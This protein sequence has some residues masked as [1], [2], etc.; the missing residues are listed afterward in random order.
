LFFK[1]TLPD[2][3]KVI[4]QVDKE[5]E[6]DLQAVIALSFPPT[7]TI[8]PAMDES[9]TYESTP[10]LP[11]CGVAMLSYGM[12]GESDETT[13]VVGTKGRLTIGTPCHCPT[14]ITIRVKAQGRGNAAQVTEYYYPLPVDLDE[15]IK[16]GGYYYPNSAGFCYEAAAVARCIG[17]GKTE[18]PQYTLSETLVEMKILEEAR[19]QLGLKT[20]YDE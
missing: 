3:I 17:S 2:T 12:L 11:G 19:R 4:G 6:V 7:G 1:G 9:I 13:I 20:I 8:A 14:N 15:I 18:C 10:K 5:T 16:A